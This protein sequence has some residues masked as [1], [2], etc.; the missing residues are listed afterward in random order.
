MGK[1]FIFGYDTPSSSETIAAIQEKEQSVRKV[2]GDL[3]AKVNE[4]KI[5]QADNLKH[6]YG[7]VVVK[8]DEQYKNSWK[9]ADG[10]QIRY[11]R[12]FNNFNRRQT[13]PTNAIVISG[14]NIPAGVEILV[15]PN[16]VHDSNRIFNYKDSNDDIKYYSIHTDMCFAWYDGERYQPI[17]PYEFALRVFKPYEGKL[18]GIQPEQ[19]KD[20]LYVT[21]GQL[22]GKVVSTLKACDYEVVYQNKDLREGNLI[23]FRPMGDKEK[24]REEEA[25][26]VLE[27]V[28]EKVLQ[29]GYLVGISLSDAKPLQQYVPNN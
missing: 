28:T 27:H 24:Q 14:E 10:T 19:M 16:A 18:E 6:V 26:A 5:S 4:E 9:F 21:S 12:G 29:G 7:R 3:R 17:P 23:R 25:V 22:K 1:H 15:H 8:I 11:E 13:S 2:S 20:T